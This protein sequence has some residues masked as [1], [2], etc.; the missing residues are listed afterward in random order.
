MEVIDPYSATGG[1]SEVS[2]IY[3]LD[4][5]Y[6]FSGVEKHHLNGVE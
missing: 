6:V 1:Y 5:A 2:I 4:L 3:P